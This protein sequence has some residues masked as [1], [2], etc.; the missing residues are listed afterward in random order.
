LPV[1]FQ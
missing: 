1:D